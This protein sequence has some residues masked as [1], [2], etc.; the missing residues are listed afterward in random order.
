MFLLLLLF[1]PLFLLLL[2]WLSVD[3]SQL[4][5]LCLQL[6]LFC[7]VLRAHG[8]KLQAYRAFLICSISLW[9]A[10]WLMQTT[11]ALCAKVLKTFVCCDELVAVT[12][13]ILVGVFGLSVDS[14][15]ECCW[16]LEK[17]K[18]RGMLGALSWFGSSMVNC[19]CGSYEL[20]CC[21]SCWLFL[22]LL[23]DKSIIHIP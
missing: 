18:C 9:S 13:K 12:M 19:I 17:P 15:D 21:S 11:V 3:V 6:N 5:M 14:G 7:R 1:I 16:D 23:D 20:M 10:C 8:E 22:W 2:G 4:F